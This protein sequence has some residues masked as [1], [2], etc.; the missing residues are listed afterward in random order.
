MAGTTTHDR[1]THDIVAKLWIHCNVL[2]YSLLSTIANRDRCQVSMAT[3][4]QNQA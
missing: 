1:L 4:S 3:H 2:N